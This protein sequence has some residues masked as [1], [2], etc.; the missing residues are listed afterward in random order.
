MKSIVTKIPQNIPDNIAH[1]SLIKHVLIKV[2]N[3]NAHD[4]KGNK[5]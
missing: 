2:I 5:V 3:N 4:K 1:H